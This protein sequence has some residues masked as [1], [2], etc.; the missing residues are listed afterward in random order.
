MGTVH[1]LTNRAHA[2]PDLL[3]GLI[4]GLIDGFNNGPG[5]NGLDKEYSRLVV[6]YL[7]A[8][9]IALSSSN[10]H[11]Q[12][13]KFLHAALSIDADWTCVERVIQNLLSD[14]DCTLKGT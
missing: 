4:N 14:Y 1:Y 13:T 3:T 9:S 8:A 10:F 7:S 12:S 11:E 2:A 6:G 5:V